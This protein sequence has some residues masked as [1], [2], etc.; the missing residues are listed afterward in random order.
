MG[1]PSFRC[2][3]VQFFLLPNPAFIIPPHV[4][5]PRAPV[6]IFMETNLQFRICLPGN[7]FLGILFMVVKKKTHKNGGRGGR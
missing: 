2:V 1:Q 3:A 4:L 6:A 5:I 7:I